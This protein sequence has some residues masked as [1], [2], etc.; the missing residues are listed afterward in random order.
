M[1]GVDNE[2]SGS[3]DVRSLLYPAIS[4]FMRVPLTDG[5]SGCGYD[6]CRVRMV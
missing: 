6:K 1:T 4:A 5:F 3:E 2:D